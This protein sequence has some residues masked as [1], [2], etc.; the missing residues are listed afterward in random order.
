MTTAQA[1]NLKNS[2]I[3]FWIIKTK[4]LSLYYLTLIENI[5]CPH[6]AIIAPKSSMITVKVTRASPL[7]MVLYL[8][9]HQQQYIKE[10]KQ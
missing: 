9:L 4:A 6:E 10:S 2:Q 3:H 1:T 5:R 8:S 7:R